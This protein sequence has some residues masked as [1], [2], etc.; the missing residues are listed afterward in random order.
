MFG[1]LVDQTLFANF[2]IVYPVI[3][4][5]L[6]TKTSK[7]DISLV[8]TS[9]HF[10]ITIFI[11]TEKYS[12]NYYQVTNMKTYFYSPYSLVDKNRTENHES[13]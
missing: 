8:S 5:N 11:K 10:S 12:I 7:T 3:K 2:L 6:L 4:I 13:N 9:V 1:F